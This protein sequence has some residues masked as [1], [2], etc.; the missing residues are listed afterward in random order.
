MQSTLVRRVPHSS[1]DRDCELHLGQ[2]NDRSHGFNLGRDAS[3]PLPPCLTWHEQPSPG[4]RHPVKREPAEPGA[5]QREAGRGGAQSVLRSKSPTAIRSNS[6]YGETL[7]A[8]AERR[9]TRMMNLRTLAQ[10]RRPAVSR[11]IDSN[12]KTEKSAAALC[13]LVCS[14]L[15]KTMCRQ[16]LASQ[17]ASERS[18]LYLAIPRSAAPRSP[19]DTSK[20]ELKLSFASLD[21]RTFCK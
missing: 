16:L 10:Q 17:A 19:E 13:L 21:I 1:H 5:Q 11:H 18:S 3:L 14:E 20:E 2:N 12:A 8:A 15:R 7:N 9:S 6:T 4:Q